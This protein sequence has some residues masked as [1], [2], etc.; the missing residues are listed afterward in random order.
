MLL[1]MWVRRPPN[2]TASENGWVNENGIVVYYVKGLPA[3]IEELRD[4]L[5]FYLPK[6][7]DHMEF[8]DAESVKNASTN[9]TLEAT[10]EIIAPVDP[11]RETVNDDS[12]NGPVDGVAESKSDD[13]AKQSQNHPAPKTQTRQTQTNNDGSPRKKPGPKPKSRR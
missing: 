13:D 6:L 2:T 4:E 11:A 3:L 5:E 8:L 9:A 12:D 7:F 10:D 1:P